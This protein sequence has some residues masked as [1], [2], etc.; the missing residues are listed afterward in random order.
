MSNPRNISKVKKASPAY[1]YSSSCSDE[2]PTESSEREWSDECRGKQEKTAPISSQSED[3][4]D[5]SVEPD[6]LQM[7]SKDYVTHRKKQDYVF[8]AKYNLTAAQQ[9]K[10]DALVKKIQPTTPMLVVIMKKT[11]VKQYP[12]L[13]LLKDYA[14]KHFP[15]NSQTIALKLPGKS[16]DW[17][18][19]FRIRPDGSARNLYLGNFVSDNCLRLGDLCIFQPM[20][21]VDQSRFTVTVHLLQK[22]SL[23]HYPVGRND[24]GTNHGVTQEK[25]ADSVNTPKG[26]DDDPKQP[27]G[28]KRYASCQMGSSRGH[29]NTTKRAAKPTSFEKSGDDSPFEYDA[30]E[31]NDDRT[32]RGPKYGLSLGSCLSGA[33]YGKVIAHVERIQPQTAVFVVVMSQRDVQLPS[34]LLIISE[35]H[36]IAH[37]PHENT[38]VTLHI[39]DNIKKWHPR[40]YIKEDKSEYMLIG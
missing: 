14:I 40:F 35:E 5:E 29:R 6:D 8:Q 37:F 27:S 38:P 12:N 16:K 21:K 33:Q 7:P 23:D 31:S 4:S 39:P 26:Y 32:P 30:F 3:L 19:E 25:V 10:I 9:E 36:A 34:P 18:C 15:R 22:E 2:Y 20:A 28:R 24:T 1:V 17:S 13:V 11:N